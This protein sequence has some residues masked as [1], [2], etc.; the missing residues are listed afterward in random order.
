[1]SERSRNLFILLL[2]LGLIAGSVAVLATKETKLG[3]D[4]QGGV[5]LVYQGKPTKQ[6]PTIT[7][8][9]LDRAVDIIRDRVDALGVA[10]PQIARS[11][12][13]Q[14]VVDLPGGRGRRAGGGP[15][16]HHGPDVLLRLGTEHPRRGLQHQPGPGQRR[17]DGDLRLLQRRAP[18]RE[19]RRRTT[20]TTPPTPARNGGTGSTRPTRPSTTACPSPTAAELWEDVARRHQAGRLQGAQDPERDPDRPRGA[21]R[22]GRRQGGARSPTPGGSSSDDPA[23]GGTDIKNPEQNFDQQGGG[24]IV[25]MEFTDK[26]KTAFHDTTRAIAER[27]VRQR[28]GRDGPDLELAPLRDRARRRAGLDAVHQLAREPGRHRRRDRRPDLRRLHRH[29]RAEPRELP[30]DRR[31]ADPARADQPLAGLGHARQAGAQPGPHG[32]ARGLRDRRALPARLLPRARRRR[33]RRALHLRAL[34]LRA[35]QARPDRP[36][37]A[38]ASPA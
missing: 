37:A 23:L 14:V 26:G 18:R 3:L 25:T 16:R 35:R 38:R 12:R 15:G 5:S 30:Q 19:V 28:A 27:G 6:Q 13:D 9:A 10:E 22:P 31:A 7:Q 34:L 4:L 17:P 29:D 33:R 36:H 1:M 32:R 11:G 20:A 8:D 21:P 24:P 2:V